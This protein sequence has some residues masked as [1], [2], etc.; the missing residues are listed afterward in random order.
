M[1]SVDVQSV[2]RIILGI[3]LLGLH[4][5]LFDYYTILAIYK[6]SMECNFFALVKLYI[7]LMISYDIQSMHCILFDY[8]SVLAHIINSLN[9]SIHFISLPPYTVDLYIELMQGE[10]L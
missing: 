3:K 2:Y 8:H 10:R 4:C 5:F 1:V 9:Q 6:P 7:V